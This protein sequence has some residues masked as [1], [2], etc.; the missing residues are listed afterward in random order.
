LLTCNYLLVSSIRQTQLLTAA[1]LYRAYN[2]AKLAFSTLEVGVA[3]T[4]FQ[5]RTSR[6]SWH[7]WPAYRRTAIC[8][9]TKQYRH[10][11]SDLVL[12]G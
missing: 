8:I 6:L 4:S 11:V 12:M 3:T 5:W 9:S 1:G 10:T 2:V 7:E